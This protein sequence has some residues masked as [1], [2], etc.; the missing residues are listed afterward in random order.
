MQTFKITKNGKDLVAGL[1]KEQAIEKLFTTV[2]DFSNG[3]IYDNEAETIYREVDGKVVAIKGDESVRAGDNYFEI[4]EEG[5][6]A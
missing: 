1:T 4:E 6:D 2:E 3:Y 5:E